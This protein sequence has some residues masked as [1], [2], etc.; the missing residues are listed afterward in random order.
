MADRL[1]IYACSGIGDTNT[2]ETYNYW[3]DNTDTLNNTRAVNSLLIDINNA[4]MRATCFKGLTDA[5]R[6]NYLNSVDLYVV[7]LKAAQQFSNNPEMLHHAGVVIGA[8]LQAGLFEFKN[9]NSE[10]RDNHLDD[11]LETAQ[12]AYY[13]NEK[14]IAYPDWMAWWRENVEDLNEATFSEAEKSKIRAAI[15][16]IGDTKIPTDP[17]QMIREAG[18]YYLYTYFTQA[19]I[20]KL[21]GKNRAIV[22]RK[23]NYQKQVY[24]YNLSYCVGICGSS[25]KVRELC[26]FNVERQFGK[27]V[28]QVIDEMV[29]NGGKVSGI[30][31]LTEAAVTTIICAIVAG[32]VQ[33]VVAL[34]GKS[35]AADTTSSG[36]YQKPTTTVVRNGQ[37]EDG[38]IPV[39]EGSQKAADFIPFIAIGAA[40]LFLMKD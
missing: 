18:T 4:W 33:I 9:L 22:E 15:A 14:Y 10:A 16:G 37:M 6:L 28:S 31:V 2:N 38:D 21:P 27:P 7:C 5:Q 23:V 3:T 12:S 26:T 11:L 25:T 20:N 19:Q 8:M 29:Q 1:K 40:A 32:I 30:G 34:I 36:D 39:N 17:M 35:A 24:N 13:S